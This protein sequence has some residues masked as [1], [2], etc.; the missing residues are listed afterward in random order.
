MFF[1]VMKTAVLILPL[2]VAWLAVRRLTLSKSANAWLYAATA[3]F[4]LLTFLGL[5][6]WAFGIAA[7]HPVF[8]VFA[9][10]T[11]AI[12]YSVVRLCNTTR[13][14]DYDNE[15]E[16]TFERLSALAR[17]APVSDL[18]ILEG[19]SWPDAPQPM[20][21]HTPAAE[22]Q[23][24]PQPRPGTIARAS[25]ATMNLLQIARSM[26]GNASSEARRIK[27]LPPP[28]RAERVSMPFLKSTESA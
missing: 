18:L 13:S 27:L 5:V 15:L 6:P 8:L 16:R 12:W 26:R 21:R 11:P 9:A 19:P 24:A 20:F 4:A 1:V 7:P 23:D 14:V 17:K 28:Q 25:E 10:M 2:T 3:L 22:P